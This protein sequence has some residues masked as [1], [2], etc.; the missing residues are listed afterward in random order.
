MIT[1]I[2]YSKAPLHLIQAIFYIKTFR[3]S[4][5]ANSLNLENKTTSDGLSIVNLFNCYFASIYKKVTSPVN[6]FNYLII[7][8]FDSINNCE[9]DVVKLDNLKL[10]TGIDPDG[11]SLIHLHCSKFILSLTIIFIFNISLI[12]DFFTSI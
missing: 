9:I 4:G 11:L 6:V 5:L 3:S 8:S 10:K 1:I 7:K 12:S 2:I